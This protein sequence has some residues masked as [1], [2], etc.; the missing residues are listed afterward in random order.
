MARFSKSTELR[1]YQ[2]P[3]GNGA[4]APIE[5]NVGTCSRIVRTHRDEIDSAMKSGEL[6]YTRD[7]E[8]RRVT[9]FEA[10]A[11]WMRRGVAR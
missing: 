2:M 3:E 11:E 4:D 6:P 5:L 8:G 10:L 1:E 7:A 9:T